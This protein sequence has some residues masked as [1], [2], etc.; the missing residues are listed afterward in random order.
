MIIPSSW[1]CCVKDELEN[2]CELFLE[3][4]HVGRC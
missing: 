2:A 3:A 4:G 1:S